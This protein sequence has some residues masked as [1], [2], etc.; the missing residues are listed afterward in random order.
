LLAMMDSS[1]DIESVYGEGS[2][3]SFRLSQQ[4]IDPKPIGNYEERVREIQH[5]EV[6]GQ[7]PQFKGADV[8]VVDDYEMNLKVARNLLR[9]FGIE[10][11]LVSSGPE[12]IE[13]IREKNYQVVLL[14]HMMP[15][16]DGIETLRELE[17]QDLRREDMAVIALTANAVVGASEVYL[18]AGFDDYLTKPID[19]EALGEMLY[20]HLPEDMIVFEQNT[21]ETAS[22]GEEVVFEFE[23]KFGGNTDAGTDRGFKNALLNAGINADEGL[24]YSAE[25]EALYREILEDFA[26]CSK[27]KISE[28]EKDLRE[29]D[30]DAYRIMIHSL[31]GASRTIGANGVALLAKALED[32]A[33]EK[34]GDFILSHHDE[35]TD[36]FGKLSEDIL[37]AL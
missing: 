7:Y 26:K 1:L 25:S 23:P 31:K 30:W 18:T 27:D 24:K 11:D 12:A 13:K 36:R 19:V 16:M 15:Q 3:F 5:S 37:E 28:L 14:D 8:L 17:R 6:A 34:N 32:A 33:K 2:A 21:E 9:I 35:F 20:R 22:S 29:K 10:A 4:I